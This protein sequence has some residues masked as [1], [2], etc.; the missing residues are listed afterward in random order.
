[1]AKLVDVKGNVKVNGKPAKK[2][3][4]INNGDR[5]SVGNGS[6]KIGDKNIGKFSALTWTEKK[7]APEIKEPKPSTVAIAKRLAGKPSGEIPT[8]LSDIQSNLPESKFISVP[9][10]PTKED[11]SKTRVKV[12][13]DYALGGIISDPFY[14]M[15]GGGALVGITIDSLN[16]FDANAALPYQFSKLLRKAGLL[17]S[18]KSEWKGLKFA[19]KNEAMTWL[20]ASPYSGLWRQAETMM[21]P[22]EIEQ[23]GRTT[24][25]LAFGGKSPR[26]LS[27][28]KEDKLK[29]IFAHTAGIESPQNA[30]DSAMV[31]SEYDFLIKSRNKETDIDR[32]I[33]DIVAK[34]SNYNNDSVYEIYKN[35]PN[36][37]LESFLHAQYESPETAHATI[38]NMLNESSVMKQTY[39]DID[40]Q[41]IESAM[42]GER[43]DSLNNLRQVIRDTRTTKQRYNAIARSTIGKTIQKNM[44]KDDIDTL[45]DAI[46]SHKNMVD[47]GELKIPNSSADPGR[48]A[49]FEMQQLGF[50][51]M[52]ISY[53]YDEWKNVDN[54]ISINTS[55]DLAQVDEIKKNY[56]RYVLDK[57]KGMSKNQKKAWTNE[58]Y[59]RVFDIAE[60][61]QVFDIAPIEQDTANQIRGIFE[62]FAEDQGLKEQDRYRQNYITHLFDGLRNGDTK[63]LPP[64][65]KK[66]IPYEMNNP[67]LKKRYGNE[68]YLKNPFSALERYIVT[69][70]KKIAVDPVLKKSKILESYFPEGKGKE[71]F[72][73]FVRNY[74]YGDD[75]TAID[76]GFDFILGQSEIGRKAASGIRERSYSG[77][78]GFNV[79]T[80]TKQKFQDI[81]TAQKVGPVNYAIARYKSLFD[82]KMKKLALDNPQLRESILTDVLNDLD[83]WDLESKGSAS[84]ILKKVDRAGMKGFNIAEYD[85]RKVAFLGGYIQ[86][87]RD[88][89]RMGMPDT[90]EL[91]KL[92]SD[93]ADVVVL[94]TQVPFGWKA[95]NLMKGGPYTKLFTQFSSYPIHTIATQTRFAG[96]ALSNAYKIG[97]LGDLPKLDTEF[98]YLRRA[99]EQLSGLGLYEKGTPVDEFT[100]YMSGAKAGNKGRNIVPSSVRATAV[101]KAAALPISY[102]VGLYAQNKIEDKTGYNIDVLDPWSYMFAKNEQG[103]MDIKAPMVPGIIKDLATYGY[104]KASR[105]NPYDEFTDVSKKDM[106][107]T[108]RQI[109]NEIVALVPGGIEAKRLI[110]GA[111][112]AKRG[113]IKYAGYEDLP[114]LFDIKSKED[115]SRYIENKIGTPQKELVPYEVV[116]PQE[117]VLQQFGFYKKRQT[118]IHAEYVYPEIDLTGKTAEEIDEYYHGQHSASYTRLMMDAVS[119]GNDER[120]GLIIDRF[121][122]I[123]ETGG[124]HPY[125]DRKMTTNKIMSL[126][127]QFDKTKDD[128]VKNEV[129]NI[130]SWLRKENPDYYGD[131]W[132]INNIERAKDKPAPFRWN[133]QSNQWNEVKSE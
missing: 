72:Q 18:F 6:A 53:H 80:M 66:A 91:R 15:G 109:K 62:R 88:A 76:R 4:E 20:H 1:M 42:S 78:L 119:K 8:V 49:Y 9:E 12:A 5:I 77:A 60:G 85:N 2:G 112:T 57:T 96:Q 50:D 105:I 55:N 34:T 7:K 40:K 29:G 51:R 122:N 82:P 14:Q 129:K 71:Y 10:I 39:E 118:P 33:V 45:T 24:A 11:L 94:E 127:K 35:E 115:I 121:K 68:E 38:A 117:Q 108:G 83:K 23:L 61:K 113:G 86:F 97:L 100:K 56:Y 13:T 59:K 28:I 22:E 19:T 64:W 37:V 63:E 58:S 123:S 30:I 32:A 73:K 81:F 52:G 99:G 84:R 41:L 126:I 70:N 43:K 128:K 130:W 107:R 125:I 48:L 106:N 79:S 31:T 132:F 87:I 65:V 101:A 103:Y 75:P 114:G 133:Y 74:V 120:K 131:E 90:P 110:G 104:E 92:A 47:S 21:S 69:S 3:Q 25:K 98:G 95:P 89:K 46:V 111:V 93:Y 54:K 124:Y 26:R 16:P 17:K 36:I 44:S 27:A 116:N 102:G 67:Y